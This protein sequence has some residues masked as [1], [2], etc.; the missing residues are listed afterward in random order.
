MTFNDLFTSINIPKPIERVQFGVLSSEQVKA[1]SVCE[2]SSTL[3]YQGNM[4][5]ENGLYDLRMGTCLNKFVCKT[6][7]SSTI[8]CPGHF[9][10]IPLASACYHIGFISTVLKVLRCVC[11]H[12]SK[13]LISH[14]DELYEE[15]LLIKNPSKRLKFIEEASKNLK[16]CGASSRASTRVAGSKPKTKSP[17]IQPGCGN[18]LYS[19]QLQQSFKIMYKTKTSTK[20][21][22]STGD[23]S[24]CKYLPPQQALGILQKVSDA[25]CKVLG[26]NV[27]YA[28][29]DWFIITHL[30]VAPPVIRPSVDFN[31]SNSF[32]DL[33]LKYMDIIKTN[34]LI[35]NA[36]KAGTAAHIL[37]NYTDLLQYHVAVLIDNE[38]SNQP[39][40]TKRDGKPFKSL[41]QR[42]VG[43][44]GRV[45]SN[46]MGKRVDFSARTV[47]TADPTIGID[48]VGVPRSI[49][50]NL[51]V[52]ETVTHFNHAKLTQLVATN[53][54]KT[55][56]R[57]DG[58]KFNLSCTNVK[59]RDKVLQLGYTVE[60]TLQ[61]GDIVLMNRQP[62]LHKM[63]MM[64]HKAKILPYSSFRLNLS[65]TT[66]YNADFDGGM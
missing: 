19:F 57:T 59:S 11:P 46:L 27:R 20:S 10:H 60:R 51:T 6:C 9:G 2:V 58:I 30:P 48:Q 63:S 13:L 52:P 49:A 55:I 21:S 3:T 14:D 36:Q 39:A 7:N 25:D 65:C 56:K 40:S 12:C 22:S 33:S 16:S 26:F 15:A 31:G 42:L 37:T 8:E 38:L 34:K 24:E 54:V 1:M 43:K 66:P 64:A 29:P 47:I 45:R 28:R 4:P 32:D 35:V 17:S 62:S 5:V 53:Q 44:G 50:N 23:D 18:S 61:D 41:R